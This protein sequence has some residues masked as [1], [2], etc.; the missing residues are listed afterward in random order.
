LGRRPGRRGKAGGRDLGRKARNCGAGAGLL[1]GGRRRE[2][3]LS[4][5]NNNGWGFLGGLEIQSCLKRLSFLKSS[6]LKSRSCLY[7]LARRERPL[8]IIHLERYG[9]LRDGGI[10][11]ARTR[12]ARTFGSSPG[13]A[14]Q[15][16]GFCRG[17]DGPPTPRCLVRGLVDQSSAEGCTHLFSKPPE[18]CRR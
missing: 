3:E 6:Y 14:F 17:I 13:E 9:S 5:K 2:V 1:L 8:P 7:A 10:A 15:P 11:W 4:K 12:G 18:V 16:C